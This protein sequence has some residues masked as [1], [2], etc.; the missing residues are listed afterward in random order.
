MQQL[1]YFIQ[2]YRYFLFF[3]LLEFIA[4]N[5]V[6]NNRSFH[7]SKFVNSANSF[8][9]GFYNKINSLTDYLHLNKEN[10]L[11]VNENLVL[12]N[13]VEKFSL[14]LA[15]I[16]SKKVDDTT[17]FNQ[18]FYF[19]EGK[20]EKNQF[21]GNYNFLTINL[22][23]ND[24]ISNEMAVI[25]SMG[26]IGIT[27]HVSNNYS[28]VQSILNRNSKINARL[29]NSSYFG[30]LMWNGV[31]YNILQLLDIPRQAIIKSGD[32]IVTGGMSTIFPA[33]I[34][35]GKVIDTEEGASIKRI[36]NIQLFNDMSNLKNIYVIKDFDK[37]EIMNLENNSN[38]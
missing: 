2:K 24:S 30:S 4:I 14:L 10:L 7:K 3:L 13:K 37:H 8:T 23:K 18:R 28:R 1:I 19:I 27:E 36:V 32:T 26:I 21:G 29:K 20:I 9:G 31:D 34:P 35:I 5:L 25:N 16:K 17:S 12:K 22:G 11:L 33:G 38:E 15:E 6:I